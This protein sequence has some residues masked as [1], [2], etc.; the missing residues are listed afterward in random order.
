[1]DKTSVYD[2]VMARTGR[3]AL[4]GKLRSLRLSDEHWELLTRYGRGEFSRGLR[5]LIERQR[6]HI[7]RV[8]AKQDEAKP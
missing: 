8:I 1:M 7:R 6:R 4:G 3:P 2:S 5:E